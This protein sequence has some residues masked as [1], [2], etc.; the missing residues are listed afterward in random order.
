MSFT[1]V[2][3][4]A[5]KTAGVSGSLLLAICT[6]ESGL[7]NTLVENDKG[8]PSYGICQIKSG[9]AA[10]VGFKGEPA[11]LMQPAVNAKYAARYLAYQLDRYDGDNCRATAAYNAG[12]YKES[13]KHPG[14]AFNVAYII[15]VADKTDV[16][17]FGAFNCQNS[18]IAQLGN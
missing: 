17:L 9:A 1:T 4:A 7:K 5:A 8:S 12:S 16:D 2:I 14:Q 18:E 6:H 15:N 13:K 3:L 10:M 11:E